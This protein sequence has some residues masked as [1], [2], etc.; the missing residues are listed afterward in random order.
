LFAVQP[1]TVV[2]GLGSC[3]P[4]PID[5]EILSLGQDQTESI[6]SQGPG[7]LSQVALFAVTGITATN[8]PSTAAADNARRVVSPAGRA[9]IHNSTLPT[10]SLFPYEPSLGVVVDQRDLTV[11]G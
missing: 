1:G 3:T 8:Y 11:G 6:S 4:G 9:V 2:N 10:L 7:G 5:C